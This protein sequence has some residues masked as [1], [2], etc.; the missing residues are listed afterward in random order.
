MDDRSNRLAFAILIINVILLLL[1][2]F[3][4]KWEPASRVSSDPTPVGF[5]HVDLR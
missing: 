1:G 2:A 3:A 5:A 4:F